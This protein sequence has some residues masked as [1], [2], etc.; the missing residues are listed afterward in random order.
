MQIKVT[1]HGVEITGP[2]RDYVHEKVSKLEEFFG[3]ILKVEVVLD[4]R[5][6]D[7]V[8]RRQVAEIRA[9]MGG[10][11]E[12]QASEGGRDMYAA[13]DMAV[14]EA[15]RQIER[16]KEKVVGGQRRKA[17]KIKQ[18]SRET[19]PAGIEGGTV[20]VRTS[21][22]AGKPM[23]REEAQAELNNLRQDFLAFR[24]TDT[25]EVNVIRRNN[26]AFDLLRPE[27]D[28]TPEEAVEELKR[29][30]EN[31]IV[32]NNSSTRASSIIFRRKSGNFGL[33][34]PEI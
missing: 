22:L 1:G 25:K 16:H 9:W 14:E 4:A 17:K 13:I 21:R 28:L 12:V 29:S 20:L 33:I 32:F 24:N 31:I 30:G 18:L 11:T 19:P 2:L 15:K 27:R 23:G 7:N 34:E 26:D 3:N 8:E 10:L 5:S 6:I